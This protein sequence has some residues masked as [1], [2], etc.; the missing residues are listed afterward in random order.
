MHAPT[1]PKAAPMC[2]GQGIQRPSKLTEETMA[3]SRHQSRRKIGGLFLSAEN[4]LPVPVSMQ[5]HL[6]LGVALIYTFIFLILAERQMAL[7]LYSDAEVSPDEDEG[8]ISEQ[9]RCNNDWND[10][11]W[12]GGTRIDTKSNP[13][14]Q[15]IEICVA[16]CQAD[17]KWIREAI[18]NEFP[19][20]VEIN[21]SIMSKCNNEA[22][23]VDFGGLSN[24]KVEVIK[25]P[26]RGGCDLAFAHFISRYFSREVTVQSSASASS[27]APLLFLKDTAANRT[28]GRL[29]SLNELLRLALQRD[30]FVCGLEPHCWMSA[31]HDVKTLESYIINSY[32]RTDGGPNVDGVQFN[33]V[34]YRNL[35]DFLDRGLNWTFPNN[36]AIQVC[37]GGRFAVTETRLL[38][39]N[40]A[41][42]EILFRR[43]EQVLMEGSAV[44]N[45][46]EHFAERLWAGILAKPLTLSQVKEILD[47]H[48]TILD[49]YGGHMGTFSSENIQGCCEKRDF[50]YLYWDS[51]NNEAQKAAKLL[52]FNQE[53]WNGDDDNVP[54]YS[55]PF[56]KLTE[57]KKKAVVYL[58][59]RSYFT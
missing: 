7:L 31:Y 55:T 3:L 47:L 15:R 43:L 54:I 28:D 2:N 30:D 42:M 46:V 8:L 25:L 16:Y 10:V 48:E 34:G 44:M 50:E 18:A 41:A 20:Q 58:G 14:L 19:R 21:L 53:I 45:V 26:N 11:L 23:I 27:T 13:L 33:P 4:I 35:S 39:G 29:R 57:D 12:S 32:T 9:I 1:I 22:D 6:M 49:E 56:D 17:L 51:L 24:V 52:G 59:L 38:N 37:Y 5:L 40:R 36:E